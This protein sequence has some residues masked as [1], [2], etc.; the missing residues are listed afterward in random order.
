M[1]EITDKIQEYLNDTVDDCFNEIEGDYD[2]DELETWD[3]KKCLEFLMGFCELELQL[4]NK[5][6]QS[7]SKL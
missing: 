5:N 2:F 7:K 6:K 4:L 1:D 3:K